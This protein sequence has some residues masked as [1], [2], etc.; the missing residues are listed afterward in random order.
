MNDIEEVKENIEE[1][2]KVMIQNQK[3]LMNKLIENQIM[4]KDAIWKRDRIK[5]ENENDR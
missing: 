5:K 2:K 1:L 4:L 3:F